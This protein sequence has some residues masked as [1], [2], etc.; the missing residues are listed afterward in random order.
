[1]VNPNQSLLFLWRPVQN[2]NGDKGLSFVNKIPVAKVELDVEERVDKMSN[3]ML[4]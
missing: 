3:D 4:E 1:M 2:R